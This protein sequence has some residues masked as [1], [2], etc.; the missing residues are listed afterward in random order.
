VLYRIA[1][2]TLACRHQAVKVAAP[3]VKMDNVSES[4]APERAADTRVSSEAASAAGRPG[5]VQPIRAVQKAVAVLNLFTSQE[6]E[7][8]LG[9]IAERLGMSRATAHR[10]LIT[11]RATN[12]L[13]YEVSRAVYSLGVKTLDYAAVVH[14]SARFASSFVRRAEP[15][16]RRLAEE[17]NYTAVASVWNGDSPV[18]VRTGTP[19]RR[20]VVIATMP[21]YS[22]LPVFDSAQGRIFLA[23]SEEARRTHALDPRL[24]DLESELERA[25]REKFVS[26][27]VPADGG[28]TTVAVPVLV[29]DT[30]VGVIATLAFR[31]TVQEPDRPL[32]R[33]AL[34][35][36]ATELSARVRTD[37]TAPQRGPRS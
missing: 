26:H 34:T 36:A 29:D 18:L 10:Y 33:K 20:M 11:L 9:D 22:C 28:T 8:T 35:Q 12:L 1:I 32:V 15:V 2:R 17:T 31:T 24:R 7:L 23:F 21:L 25:R 13:S 16:L 5:G 3:T 14:D 19:V 30:L 27:D 37:T 4:A 6:P